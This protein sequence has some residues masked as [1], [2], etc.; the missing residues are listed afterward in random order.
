MNITEA[1]KKC[2]MLF[3]KLINFVMT[4]CFI[5][6]FIIVFLLVLLR[7]VFSASLFGGAEVSTVLFIYG[8]A[9]GASLLYRDRS[10]IRISFFLEKLPPSLSKVV[11]IFAYFCNIFFHVMI[12]YYAID[13]I[14]VTGGSKTTILGIPYWVQESAIFV[15]AG[16]TI[17]YIIRNIILILFRKNYLQQ[18]Q[19]AEYTGL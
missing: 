10:H 13:W 14:R 4:V 17:I 16:I 6:I 8:T 3:T 18:E 5:T 9:I 12:I 1:T 19:V 7:Y 15:Y 11:I 2:E